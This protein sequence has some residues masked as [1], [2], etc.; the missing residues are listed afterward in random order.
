MKVW[1]ILFISLNILDFYN[2]ELCIQLT[3]SIKSALN[4][5]AEEYC[6]RGKSPEGK[7][8]SASVDND[9]CQSKP[10]SGNECFPPTIEETCQQLL[11]GFWINLA[12]TINAYCR[13][14]TDESGA[15]IFNS[16]SLRCEHKDTCDEMPLDRCNEFPVDD[17]KKIC[18]K[19]SETNKCEI[20]DRPKK[21]NNKANFI[22]KISLII[23]ILIFLI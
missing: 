1:L 5:P 18:S 14:A 12:P 17:E 3:G 9:A 13:T 23:Y 6:K 16:A 2:Q 21:K 19:N 8:C 4:G 10:C 15:C 20:T 11:E 22:N 7:V